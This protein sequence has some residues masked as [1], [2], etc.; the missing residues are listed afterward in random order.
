MRGANRRPPPSSLVTEKRSVT[1]FSTPLGITK[2]S[3]KVSGASSTSYTLTTASL[4]GVLPPKTEK[5]KSV[6]RRARRFPTRS[7]HD[8]HDT[9]THPAPSAVDRWH[10]HNPPCVPRATSGTATDCPQGYRLITL[11][12]LAERQSDGSHNPDYAH[13]DA[14]EHPRRHVRTQ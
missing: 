11:L 12:E 6:V 4:F 2:F 5:P 7:L 14:R 3:G 1:S 8:N 10:C 9:A 13:H